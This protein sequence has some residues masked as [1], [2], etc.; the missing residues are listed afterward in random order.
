M[1]ILFEVAGKVHDRMKK[2][3]T[4]YLRPMKP[5]VVRILT[6]YQA[7]RGEIT[8]RVNKA[9][10]EQLLPNCIRPIVSTIDSAQG[11][12]AEVVI[13][14]MCRV[15]SLGFMSGADARVLVACSR[16]QDLLVVLAHKPTFMADPRWRKLAHRATEVEVR[17]LEYRR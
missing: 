7:Q 11:Q 9:T 13:V 3:A 14:S 15:G 2:M 16:A 8:K 4:T 6:P 10:R 12:E 1:T 5:V 17:Q